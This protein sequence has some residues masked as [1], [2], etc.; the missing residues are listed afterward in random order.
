[1]NTKI[2]LKIINSAVKFP[3]S[4]YSRKLTL[5]VSTFPEHKTYIFNFIDNIVP[6]NHNYFSEA[7][8]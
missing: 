8:D 6:G 2:I 7:H 4:K 5:Y 1:M 3:N